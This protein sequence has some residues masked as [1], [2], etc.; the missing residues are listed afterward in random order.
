M[1]LTLASVLNGAGAVLQGAAPYVGAVVS[2]INPA[3]GAPPAGTDAPVAPPPGQS[4][5][6]GTP[7]SAPGASAPPPAAP[8]A[9][10]VGGGVILGALA[11][12]ALVFVLS[13]QG[14][15]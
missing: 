6:T 1:D 4:A 15:K 12:I 2:A 13:P 10:K 3:P 9:G 5:P 11:L 7:A 8:V 14:K